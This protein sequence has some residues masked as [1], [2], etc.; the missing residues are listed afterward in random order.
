MD[1][2]NPVRFIACL[3]YKEHTAA[4]EKATAVYHAKSF[5]VRRG[6]PPKTPACAVLKKYVAYMLKKGYNLIQ[7]KGAGYVRK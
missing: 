7:E 2:T 5:Q 4:T 1:I 3:F 6:K